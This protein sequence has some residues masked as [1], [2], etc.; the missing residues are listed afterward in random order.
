MSRPTTHLAQL[1]PARPPR[2]IS[3]PARSLP[4]PAAPRAVPPCGR[5]ARRRRAR[6]VTP[7]TGRG[8]RGQP[9][10]PE[11]ARAHVDLQ[12]L[13]LG[14]GQHAGPVGRARGAGGDGPLARGGPLPAP[15][16]ARG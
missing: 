15:A 12:L 1:F 9:G 7:S 10:G 13:A 5:G 3:A 16:L 6:R 11:Y 8:P 14:P 2:R 4:P